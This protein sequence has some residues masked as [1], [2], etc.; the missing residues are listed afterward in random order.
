MSYFVVFF[1]SLFCI[2]LELFYT[3]ILNLKAWNHIV[4][5]IIPFAI[6]GYG[7]GANLYLIF[8]KRMERCGYRQI[9]AGSLLALSVLSILSTVFLISFPLSL[10]YLT[11]FLKSFDSIFRLSLAYT[12]ILLPFSVIGFLI[13]YFF[14]TDSSNINKL[15]FWDLLGAG[16]GAV[17]FFFLINYLGVF[18]SILFF[19]IIALF[20][21]ICVILNLR[22]KIFQMVSLM[23]ILALVSL[24]FIPEPVNYAIDESKGWEWIPGILLKNQYQTLVSQWHPLGRTEVYRITDSKIRERMYD[25]NTMT[26]EINLSPLPEFAY[27]A[28]NALS[29]TP[30]YKLSLEGLRESNSEVKIF[31][32]AVEV[33]YVILEKPR[34]MV[35]GTGGGRDIFMAKTHRAVEIQ[36]AEINPAIYTQMSSGGKLYDYSGRIYTQDHVS[37]FNIDGRHLVKKAKSSYF[38]LIILNGVDTFSGLS[39]GAYAYAESYLYTKD[40][41]ADYLNILK[42]NGI[43]NFN[44]WFFGDLPREELRLFAICLDALRSLGVPKPWE[45]IILGVHRGWVLML[46]KKDPFTQQERTIIKDYFTSHNTQLIFSSGDTS[47]NPYQTAENLFNL[48]VDSFMKGEEKIFNEFYPYDISVISDDSPFFY[49]YFK[50]NFAHPLYLEIY[51][52]TGTIIFLTQILMLLQAV[53]FI[54]LFIFLPLIIFKLTGIRNMPGRGMFRFIFYFA[55]LG[56]GYMFIEIPLMQRFTLLLGTPIHSISVTLAALLISSGVGSYLLPYLRRLIKP[57]SSPVVISA[58][59]LAILLFLLISTGANVMNHFIGLS[60]GLRVMIVCLVLLP[61]GICLGIFFPSGLQLISQKYPES[62]AWA[63]GIN[64]GF[65]VLG[66]MLAIILAQFYGFNEILLLSIAIYLLAL[67]SFGELEKILI[68]A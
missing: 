53:I 34:V 45:H 22:R 61:I 1:I 2:S 35:I 14:S 43:I 42:P 28:T 30:I 41:V 19:S 59:I 58:L 23:I 13:T 36:G 38:D 32:E 11:S 50:F 16:T 31:S 48:Y 47:I 63:W 44:R 18:R 5:I 55:C 10:S 60:F 62:I 7:V 51:H 15:Y 49:K 8:K 54:V 39:T 24:R 6:L 67:I 21:Y 57:G 40:A 4:Y 12:A 37:V 33:P 25:L 52:H 65:S 3:R 17:V 9:V 56:M 46:V 20:L 27:A 66:S 68:N 29:G 64:A 26:F